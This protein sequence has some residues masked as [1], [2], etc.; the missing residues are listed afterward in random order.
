MNKAREVELGGGGTVVV[1]VAGVE[2]EGDSASACLEDLD[3]GVDG[4][5]EELLFRVV[6]ERISVCFR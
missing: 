4:E 3:G 2:V 5:G 1:V 6:L